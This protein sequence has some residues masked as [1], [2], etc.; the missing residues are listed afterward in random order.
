MTFKIKIGTHLKT[1]NPEVNTNAV[2]LN[3]TEGLNLPHPNE[4]TIYTV[5]TDYGNIL[6][7]VNERELFERYEIPHWHFEM[8][9]FKEMM[10][11]VDSFEATVHKM[12]DD[13]EARKE[14]IEKALEYV[15]LNLEG[16]LL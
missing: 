4:G 6:I 2:I 14:K 10:G 5:L 9:T 8:E 1:K 13:L 3:V 15:K 11:E 7:G 12:K 16:M